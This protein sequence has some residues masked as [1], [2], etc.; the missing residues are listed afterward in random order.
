M[1]LN[2][3]LRCDYYRLLS[4]TPASLVRAAATLQVTVSG[5]FLYIVYIIVRFHLYIS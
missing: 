5:L 2:I 1:G 3:M 4:E